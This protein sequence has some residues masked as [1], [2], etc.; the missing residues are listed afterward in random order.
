VPQHGDLIITA[1]TREYGGDAGVGEGG[2]QIGR[3]ILGRR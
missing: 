1:D 3:A 2:V